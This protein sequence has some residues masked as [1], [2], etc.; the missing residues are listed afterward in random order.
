MRRP[1]AASQRE[2]PYMR[3]VTLDAIALTGLFA[4][5]TSAAIAQ[6]PDTY[7]DRPIKVVV[8]AAAGGVTDVPARIV[9]NRMREDLGQTLVVENQGAPAAFWH[10]RASSARRRTATRC[11]TSTPP[12]MAC[13][14]R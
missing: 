2:E 8:P 12:P 13:C 11:S 4:A 14:R 3:R 9:T 10:P 5:L 7:P 6:A 1:E